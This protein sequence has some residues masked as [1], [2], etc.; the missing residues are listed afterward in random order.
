MISPM[1]PMSSSEQTIVGKYR[2]EETIGEGGMATVWRARHVELGRLVAVK[3]LHLAGPR[4]KVRERFLREARVA[5]A[6]DHRNV[7]DIIDFGTDERGDPYMVMEYLD[8]ETLQERL[9]SGKAISFDDVIRIFARTLSGLAAVHEAKIVHRDIKPAN[10]FVL[11]DADG[12]YPKLL[13]FGV[14]RADENDDLQSVLPSQENALTGTPRY[15]SPEQARGLHDIDHRTDIY[16]MGTVLYETLAGAPPYDGN[17]VGDLII[18][19]IEASHTPFAERRP[20]LGPQVAAVV[21][22]AMALDRAD[23]FQTARE[24]RRALLQAATDT[25]AD[26]DDIRGTVGGN[27]G[28]SIFPT[29]A[30]GD[31]R[32][33]VGDSLEPDESGIVPSSEYPGPP[34]PAPHKAKWP[35]VI[36]IAVFLMVAS[37]VATYQLRDRIWPPPADTAS[38]PQSASV[39]EEELAADLEATEAGAAQDQASATEAEADAA[40]ASEGDAAGEASTVTV[41]L[42]AVPRR[43]RIFVDGERHASGPITFERADETHVI[44]VRV[45]RRRPFRVE[46]N[47]LED[48]TY[49]V[50]AARP[51]GMRRMRRGMRDPGMLLGSPG[52]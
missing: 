4:E 40:A 21:E 13:D 41:T 52:F 9:A 22:K 35:W 17:R 19:I 1:E 6:V 10:I 34:E 44:E 32:S 26:L 36:G 23:R 42:E 38:A 8:G 7:V 3:F 43:A 14:S 30:A 15:M 20:D 16:A 5:A 49:R 31:L 28:D 18:E 12:V 27:V 48:G 39:D 47:A 33:A 51:A 37:G 50:T 29:T 25:A 11:T 24:F 46:H 2:L 45:R